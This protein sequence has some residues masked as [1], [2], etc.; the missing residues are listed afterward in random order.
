MAKTAI[1]SLKE[2]FP[3]FTKNLLLQRKTS[4]ISH[5]I[6]DTAMTTDRASENYG[7]PNPATG[8][9]LP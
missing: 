6:A 8:S 4:G 7:Y 9:L 2:T 1:H 5:T 3:V